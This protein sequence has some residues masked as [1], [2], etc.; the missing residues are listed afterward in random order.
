MKRK[1]R[2]NS[3][4]SREAGEWT[5]R[6]PFFE[7][8]KWRC[9]K[10]HKA[11]AV[12][13]LTLELGQEGTAQRLDQVKEA[14]RAVDAL[15]DAERKRIEEAAKDPQA[16]TIVKASLGQAV[17]K[18]LGVVD[19]GPATRRDYEG[20]ARLF[21]DKLGADRLIAEI[22]LSD[23]ERAFYQ[24]WAKLKGQTKVKYRMMLSRIWRHAMKHGHARE[25]LPEQVGED[26]RGRPAPPKK[27]LDDI[28]AA[29]REAGRA[30]SIE[31]ALA[32]LEA[33]RGKVVVAY[34]RERF[35]RTEKI[36]TEQEIPGWLWW[37]AFISLRTGLRRSNVI[38]SEDKPGLLWRNVD[39]ERKRLWI[40]GALMKS[41]RPYALPD[42]PA[43]GLP[44]HDELAE[45][46]VKLQRSLGR[47]PQDDEPVLPGA[48]GA[49]LAK[50]ID[51]AVRRAGI[52]GHVRPHDL[53]HT[54]A[55]W[56]GC[57]E[58]CPEA[59]KRILLSHEG[60]DVTARYDRHQ[61]E[62][63]VRRGV[64]SLPRLLGEKKRGLAKSRQG[65]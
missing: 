59:I 32:L 33:C 21:K 13:R 49:N 26:R 41:K 40:E 2:R 63:A 57:Q 62:E 56:L 19:V 28:R 55:S 38:G 54:F 17:E 43:I 51:A 45:E 50:A 24:T 1:S 47:I 36:E 30:L 18:W 4:W 60:A 37:F 53:K 7:D 65:A 44:L 31:E 61:V 52:A 29:R 12:E 27:W 48:R 35:N 58:G 42:Q 6:H 15:V 11:G 3:T 10:R 16:R 20:C 34:E 5:Y 22:T 46:L 64:N 25:N 14:R 39:L 23:M 9:R 8:G